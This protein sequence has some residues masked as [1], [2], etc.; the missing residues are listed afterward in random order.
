MRPLLHRVGP[1]TGDRDL[2]TAADYLSVMSQAY[3]MGC[4][5]MQFIGGEPQLNPDF[6][7]LLVASK[8]IGFEFVEVFTNLTRL[9]EET[10]RFAR[11][12]GV[13][14][15]TSV[16]SDR[17]EV[18]AAITRSARATRGRSRTSSASST[19]RSSPGPR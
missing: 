1:Q 16:Y 17:P 15:A 6:R 4:R 19:A 11:S 12:A 7:R 3:A 18:H 2:L 8:A 14:F 5:R 9:D 10:V 13:R